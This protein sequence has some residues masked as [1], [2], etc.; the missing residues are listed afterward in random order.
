MARSKGKK[1]AQAAK[2]RFWAIAT[3]VSMAVMIMST[4]TGWSVIMQLGIYA[5]LISLVMC[6]IRLNGM[7]TG[8]GGYDHHADPGFDD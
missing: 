2:V 4:F 8:K 5:G 1:A 6:I 3:A 7:A